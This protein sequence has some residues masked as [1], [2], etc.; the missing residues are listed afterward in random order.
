MIS[1]QS[2]FGLE[3]LIYILSIK[4]EC[5]D[6]L[7][8]ST[9]SLPILLIIIYHKFIL[10]FIKINKKH[11]RFIDSRIL[12]KSSNA[13]SIKAVSLNIKPK[14]PVVAQR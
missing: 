8:I 2:A 9:G 4:L 12:L 3:A 11:P 7:P 13:L 1:L 14:Y 6:A 5:I 10:F